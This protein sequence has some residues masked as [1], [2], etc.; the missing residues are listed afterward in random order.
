MLPVREAVVIRIVLRRMFPVLVCPCCRLLP[1]LRL[2][3][4]GEKWK[5]YAK[6]NNVAGLRLVAEKLREC[7]P[8]TEEI[9]VSR[10][11]R[12]VN[13]K[14]IADTSDT[15]VK[16]AVH[17]LRASWK[18][19]HRESNNY[20]KLYGEIDSE[21]KDA[22]TVSKIYVTCAMKDAG[23]QRMQDLDMFEASMFGK[24]PE[25][26]EELLGKIIK[27]QTG[28]GQARRDRKRGIGDADRVVKVAETFAENPKN[29][30][31]TD[32]LIQREKGPKKA[33]MLHA[34]MCR[35]DGNVEDMMDIARI[36]TVLES[37]PKS[38]PSKLSGVR[39][40]LTFASEWLKK[41]P[42]DAL[43]PK[44]NELIFW[45]RFFRAPGT[46]MNYI[47]AL[48]WAC[49]IEGV[50]APDLD[51]PM[52]RRIKTSLKTSWTPQEKTWVQHWALEKLV[53][54][55]ETA[56]D[57][58]HVMLYLLSYIC[59]LRVPSEGLPVTV[60]KEMV[61][62]DDMPAGIHAAVA[63]TKTELVYYVRTRKNTK[64]PTVI[65]RQCW[66]GSRPAICPVHVFGKWW[67][68]QVS[69]HC[70]FKTI[71]PTMATAGLRRR[72]RGSSSRKQTW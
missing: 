35:T 68:T 14:S 54:G 12:E 44:I 3:K 53:K 19:V 4:L 5:Q 72:W 10:V 9:M 58:L 33:C 62:P 17:N 27:M 50:P 32:D 52:I 41:R 66:C 69:G 46:F 51:H 61:D 56:D 38:I 23:V 47:A 55:A 65:K 20:R 25:K 49:D 36:L 1:L 45:G 11:G 37:A 8:I 26:A 48:K 6:D 39:C 13:E 28:L 57:T 64:L 24:M 31:A 15:K 16:V 67:E 60:L 18:N 7:R 59:L 43:P 34:E 29:L 71:T 22:E 63:I 30:R 2:T 70:P 42:K 40:W 21:F